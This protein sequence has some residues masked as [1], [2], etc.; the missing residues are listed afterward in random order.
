MKLL[1][2]DDERAMADAIRDNLEYEGYEVD[3]AYGGQQALARLLGDNYNLVVLDVMMPDLDGFTVLTRLRQGKDDTPVI[4]LTACST[5]TDKLRG[6]SLGADDYLVKPF[7][8]LELIA[9]VKAVLHR[10]TPGSQ[11]ETLDLGAARVDLTHLTVSLNGRE[12]EL[13]RYEA[14][15]LRL[16]ASEPGRVFSRDEILDHV[17]GVDALPTNRTVDNYLVK[18]RQKI[19]PSPKHP[20]H[21]LTVYGKGYRLVAE[22]SCRD[23]GN[24]ERSR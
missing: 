10:T 17:W 12:Q 5:E 13:G 19:E 15:I 6:L 1:V 21:L 23:E 7:S 20:R 16:L 18:L 9:R 4:F 11:L 3:C 14:D 22:T 24:Q 8:I 2:V